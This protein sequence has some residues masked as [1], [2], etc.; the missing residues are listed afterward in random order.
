MK[1]NQKHAK[2]SEKLTKNALSA[3]FLIIYPYAVYTI[4]LL[5]NLSPRPCLLSNNCCKSMSTI[6]NI[7][8][9]VERNR[10]Q[11]PNKEFV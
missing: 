1:N 4:L 8:I 7:Q 6:F 3:C 11:V 10:Q 9:L 5:S 2:M